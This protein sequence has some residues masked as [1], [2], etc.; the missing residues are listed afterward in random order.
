MGLR[1]GE[2][3]KPTNFGGSRDRGRLILT[4]M[5]VS[6]PVDKAGRARINLLGAGSGSAGREGEGKVWGEQFV[7]EKPSQPLDRDEMDLFSPAGRSNKDQSRPRPPPPAP[8]P[9]PVAPF[10]V[11]GR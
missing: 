5:R 1:K 4:G 9:R 8:A 6:V 7:N 3:A 11:Q 2:S 10:Q